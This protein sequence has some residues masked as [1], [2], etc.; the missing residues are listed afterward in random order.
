MNAK[1][2]PGLVSGAIATLSAFALALL[3]LAATDARAGFAPSG[4]LLGSAD[5]FITPGVGVDAKGNSLTVWHQGAAP[6]RSVK[7]RRALSWGLLDPVM[8]LSPPGE[9]S[10]NPV[11]AFG[12]NGRA[13]V[14]WQRPSPSNSMAKARWVEPDGSLGPVLTLKSASESVSTVD[15]RA[16]VDSAGTATVAWRNDASLP[17]RLQARRIGPD[18]ALGAPIDD[19][20][21]EGVDDAR[22]AALP[23]GSTLAVWRSTKIRSNV[24]SP[25]GSAGAPAD[26]SVSPGQASPRLEVD[27]EGNGLVTWRGGS[28]PWSILGRRTGPTG[29]AVG[30]ELTIDPPATGF[31]DTRV[32]V[33]ADSSRHF[34]ITWDRQDATGTHVAYARRVDSDAN[35]A[36]PAQVVSA[37][38]GSSGAGARGVVPFVEDRGSGAVA[39]SLSYLPL[40]T[41]T[42]QGRVLD[43]LAVPVGGVSFLWGGYQVE[44]A[45]TPS[46]GVAAFVS[47]VPVPAPS[48]VLLTLDRYL[49]P[50]LCSDSQATVVQGKTIEV[51]LACSGP[52][53]SSGEVV[54][55]PKHGTVSRL[56]CARFPADPSWFYGPTPGFEGSDSFTYHVSNEGGTSNDARMTIR[57][58]KDTVRPVIKHFRFVRSRSPAKASASAARNRKSRKQ[59]FTFMLAYSEE[60]TAK[61]TVKQPRRGLLR[62]NRCRARGHGDRSAGRRCTYYGR[63]GSVSSKRLALTTTITVRGKLLRRL[64]RDGRFRATAVATDAAAN[65]SKSKRLK[66]RTKRR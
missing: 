3:V 11:V 44:G 54:E 5:E 28:D 7:A 1:R 12:P 60:A 53:A 40:G 63:I 46:G 9:D 26:L 37:G 38:G 13:I 25:N 6:L 24:V 47:I 14:A 22:I 27:S 64:R 17:T 39:W 4:A 58:G 55:R 56:C 31:V 23:D 2:L 8:D 41:F 59:N 35:F 51:P 61:V 36:G 15:L 66:I 32:D 50:P 45:G 57:V 34:L 29:A 33:S 62:G 18:G 43:S 20:S 49:V 48:A 65:R 42:T 52:T 16:V 21:G 30:N 10:I 19:V